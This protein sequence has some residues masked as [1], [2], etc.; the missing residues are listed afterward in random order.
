MIKKNKYNVTFGGFMGKRWGGDSLG[1]G[2]QMDGLMMSDSSPFSHCSSNNLQIRLC[3]DV[4]DAQF[5]TFDMF[6]FFLLTRFYVYRL[7]F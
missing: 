1:S 5:S 7:S 2:E 4:L 6:V 3:F